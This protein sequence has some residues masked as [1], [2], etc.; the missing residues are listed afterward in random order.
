MK[1]QVKLDTMIYGMILI[2]MIG[3]PVLKFI[4]YVPQISIINPYLITRSRVYFMWG[5]VIF[6]LLLYFYSIYDEE[7]KIT[8]YDYILYFLIAMAVIATVFSVDVRKSFLGEQYRYEGLFTML[9]YYLL[10]LNAKNLKSEKYKK[11]L[12]K[13]FVYIGIFQSLYAILQSFTP[14]MYMVSKF[15]DGPHMAM[16]LCSNPNFFGL[17]MTM[18]IS[19]ATIYFI[20][21]GKIRYL[22]LYI[23]FS[24]ALYTASSSGPLLAYVL[25]FILFAILMR[26]YYKRIAI[27]IFIFIFTCYTADT[28]LKY[29][30][31][32]VYN[33]PISDR[34][35][36]SNDLKDTVTKIENDEIKK[37]G[38]GRINLW[39]KSV[40]LIKEYWLYGSGLDTFGDVYPQSGK[41]FYDKAHNVYIQI[42]VTNGIFALVAYMLIC[43][44][45]F[46]KGFKLEKN[47]S[48]AL[49]MAF[50]SYC[51]AA[52]ANI[53][54]IDV[55]PCFY[56]ILG[57]LISDVKGK[58]L[59]KK[60]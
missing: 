10:V 15:S 60:N 16:G 32:R 11:N 53:S 47:Y 38:S 1:K 56:I 55:A 2:I 36:I 59:N 46:L 50:V 42:G 51:I 13:C 54:T 35:V 7:R 48:I 4:T 20:K 34:Y 26:K 33:N 5:T 9:H 22:L 52:F 57:L 37:V 12:L 6:L 17:Y 14:F 49:F 23:L 27:L 24:I 21:T 28:V 58:S 19:I 39:L 8:Y 44:I 45:V 30:H 25:S 31:I 3:I 40:P 18:Q 41:I 43:L 29:L